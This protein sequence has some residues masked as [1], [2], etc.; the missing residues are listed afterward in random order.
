MGCNHR[1][2]PWCK[3]NCNTYLGQ[4]IGSLTTLTQLW[5]FL[6]IYSK[7]TKNKNAP[8]RN[9]FSFETV[10]SGDGRGWRQGRWWSWLEEEGELAPLT[11]EEGGNRWMSRREK[12]VEDKVRL[13]GEKA[14]M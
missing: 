10:A 3:K 8:K 1:L 12:H 11:L 2:I 6:A 4:S 13:R 5:C 9:L 7:F 14:K